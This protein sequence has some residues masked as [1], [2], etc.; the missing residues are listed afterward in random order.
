MGFPFEMVL[1]SLK[2]SMGYISSHILFM[3]WQ[4]WVK[5][6]EWEFLGVLCSFCAFQV[7]SSQLI[8]G[9][10][11]LGR[12]QFLWS[13]LPIFGQVN[14]SRRSSRLGFGQVNSAATWLHC[15]CFVI[16]AITFDVEVRIAIHLKCHKLGFKGFNLIYKIIYGGYDF[17]WLRIFLNQIK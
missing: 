16:L 14:S 17:K 13:F 1:V 5:K 15:A 8:Y 3:E 6:L 10:S 7:A 4:L 9:V 12:S 2:V 11:Q